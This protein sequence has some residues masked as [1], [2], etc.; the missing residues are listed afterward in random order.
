MTSTEAEYLRNL[1]TISVKM[2]A[3][4]AR[5]SGYDGVPLDVA[6]EGMKLTHEYKRADTTQNN[7]PAHTTN[8]DQFRQFLDERLGPRLS[9]EIADAAAAMWEGGSERLDDLESAEQKLASDEHV[10]DEIYAELVKA[11]ERSRKWYGEVKSL[12]EGLQLAL[13]CGLPPHDVSGQAM[14]QRAREALATASEPAGR[15]KR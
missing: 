6:A 10:I 14:W 8:I 2:A 11:E 5:L 12:R 15:A 3:F 4:C 9:E 7:P 13:M 1:Q